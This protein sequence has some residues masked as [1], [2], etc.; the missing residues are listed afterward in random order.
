M[1]PVQVY[2]TKLFSSVI[3][4]LYLYLWLKHNH[5]KGH[6]KNDEWQRQCNPVLELNSVANCKGWSGTIQSLSKMT[7]MYKSSTKSKSSPAVA[8]NKTSVN[9]ILC[10]ILSCVLLNEV[11]K[12]NLCQIY[13]NQNLHTLAIF[14]CFLHGLCFH[15]DL[16]T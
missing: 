7:L 8:E 5:W 3:I 14:I 13:V 12:F 11:L 4:L 15:Q 16:E 9:L 1:Y 6:F 10:Y 2:I